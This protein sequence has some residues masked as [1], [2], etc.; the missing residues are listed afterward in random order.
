MNAGLQMLF[1]GLFMLPLSALFDDYSNLQFNSSVWFA[2]IYLILVGSIVAYIC[3]TFAIKHLP[4]TIVSLYAYINP[5]VAVL[6]GWIILDEKFTLYIFIAMVITVA[7]V[8]LVNRGYHLRKEWK[9]Q[10]IDD[11]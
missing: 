3:F 2:L 8:Y 11:K 5:L 4:M 1:G 9:A 7:G 10:L 6:L